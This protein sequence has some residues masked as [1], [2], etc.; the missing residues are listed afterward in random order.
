MNLE[1][2]LAPRRYSGYNRLMMNLFR[3]S[4]IS[5]AGIFSVCCSSAPVGAEPGKPLHWSYEGETGPNN[6]HSLN[7]LY[8]IA[9]DGKAQSPI[10]IVTA[11]LTVSPDRTRP[12]ISY[13]KTS[14]KIENNGHSIELTPITDGNAISID[15]ETYTLRQF[16]F[17]APSEHSVDGKLFDMEMHLVHGND[18]GALAVLG[19]MITSGAANESLA[20]LFENLPCKKGGEG[21][22][23]EINLADIFV[24]SGIVYRYDGSLTTPPCSQGVKWTIYMPPITLSRAQIEAF[25]SIYNGNNRPIQNKYGRPVYTVK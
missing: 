16:H 6:W 8:A 4:R 24:D 10:D 17:H 9:K 12:V 20:K 1:A 7:P 23:V 21:T 18:S 13:R 5:K 15:G 19:F 2:P 14:F 22:E 25:T 11:D 3:G